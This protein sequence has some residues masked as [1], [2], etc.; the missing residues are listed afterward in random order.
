MLEIKEIFVEISLQNFC[1]QIQVYSLTNK[2]H[3]IWKL[4]LVVLYF[5]IITVY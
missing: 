4:F 3:H 1:F 5:R 2:I